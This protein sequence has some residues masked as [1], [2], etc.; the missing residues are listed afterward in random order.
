MRRS[1]LIIAGVLLLALFA[2]VGSIVLVKNETS[3]DLRELDYP[4]SR[5]ETKHSEQIPTSKDVVRDDYKQ[6]KSHAQI[7]DSVDETTTNS[8]EE[9]TT[10]SPP[11][12]YQINEGEFTKLTESQ[13]NSVNILMQKY[14]IFH[15]D[16]ISSN[17][18]SEDWERQVQQINMELVN[19]LGSDI[20]G[21]LFR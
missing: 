6:Q 18:S 5:T 11:M 4:Y 13:Q 7:V 8:S 10:L 14:I 17:S 15:N 16:Y 3:H 20:A 21:K 19:S 1:F 9:V 2:Y 12:F